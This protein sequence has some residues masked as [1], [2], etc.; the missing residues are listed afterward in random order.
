MTVKDK[1]IAY[2]LVA[3]E[4]LNLSNVYENNICSQDTE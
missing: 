2:V 3:S 1:Q 4:W